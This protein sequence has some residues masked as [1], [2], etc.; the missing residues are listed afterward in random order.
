MALTQNLLGSM[1]PSQESPEV[2]AMKNERK[3]IQSYIRAYQRDP[4]NWSNNMIMQL[5]QM[6]AQYQVPFKRVVPE[7]SAA[8]NAAGAL[9]G[10][11]DSVALGFIPDKWYSDESN[12]QAANIGKIGGAAAQIAAAIAATVATGGGAA[13]T[14]GKALSSMGTAVKAAQGLGKVGAAVKGASTLARTIPARM[15][16]GQMTSGAIRQGAKALTPYGKGKGWKWA[17]GATNVAERSATAN[18]LKQ[19][20]RAID[21]TGDLGSVVKGQ[22][23][24]KEHI[25]GLTNKITAKYGKNSKVTKNYLEQLKTHKSVSG[26]DNVST[27]QIVNMANKMVKT[28]NVSSANVK[29]LLKK[30]GAS[31]SDD[32]V[33]LIVDKL[34]E[35]NI[36]KLDEKAVAQ[37]MKMVKTKAPDPKVGLGDIDKW[38]ALS[39]AGL[40]V[41]AGMSLMDYTPSREDLEKQE[42][43]YDPYNM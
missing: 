34:R 35:A 18:V 25:A 23:L 1:G 24:S 38:G 8:W 36:T 7:A 9:G 30:V 2:K 11:A 10:V 5:E 3:R 12:R 26:L 22:N 39:S 29:K 21:K 28:H 15:P 42:D 31:D 43:P 41:G 13:P 6:S 20:T 37:L 16:V 19:A 17:E 40:G 27:E 4:K 32:N 33:K 14:I